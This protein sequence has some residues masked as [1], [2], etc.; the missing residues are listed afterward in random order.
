MISFV[1]VHKNLDLY[2]EII[3]RNLKKVGYSGLRYTLHAAPY[4]DINGKPRNALDP[5]PRILNRT[6][7]AD[8]K[9]PKPLDQARMLF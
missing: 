4:I 3:S 9:L 7:S 5:T 6:S 2:Q 8:P 1:R